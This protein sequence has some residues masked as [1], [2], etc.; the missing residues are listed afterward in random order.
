MSC[1]LSCQINE[2]N[3]KG[4]EEA[5]IR[6]VRETVR[7]NNVDKRALVSEIE[8]LK[9][10]RNAVILAHYYTSSD[11]QDVADYVGD[12]F[13]LSKK[14]AQFDCETL[15]FCGVRFMGESA[16]LLSPQKT[17]L[18][19]APEADCPMAHMVEDGFIER[20]REIYE[21][22]A[23]VCY[24]NSTARIKALSDVCVTSSNALAVVSSLPERNIAFVPDRHLG[25]FIAEMLPEKNF[26]LNPG[27]C[28]IHDA[29]LAEEIK[30]LKA[31]HP[32]AK[33]LVHPECNESVMALAD[34]AGS[35]AGII[36]YAVRGDAKEYI[37][38][39]VGGVV[40]QM[41]RMTE[42]SGKRFFL[43]ATK[44]TCTDMDLVTLENV[45]DCLRAG[46]GSCYEVAPL[47]DSEG[48]RARAAML[49]MLELSK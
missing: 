40:H 17:V 29:M 26:I 18:L 21:D 43:P 4:L 20:V 23:V 30:A 16:K 3:A 38:G 49:R 25:R 45:R 2:C 37:V 19:P 47:P 6:D 15:V 33:V 31:G 36:D 27:Y 42:G 5:E 12:S 28:P 1:H 22:L 10:Q 8:E 13:G 41:K 46:V 7:G 24:V 32:E 14:A 44:P 9:K 34:Y 39:T 11:V 35:T 48:Q